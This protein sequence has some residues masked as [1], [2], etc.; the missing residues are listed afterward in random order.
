M[1]RTEDEETV[2]MMHPMMMLMLANQREH[3]VV[4]DAEKR[5]LLA[6]A[7]EARRA[8]KAQGVRGRP[9]GTLAS[10]EPSAAVPA[11]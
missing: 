10:C 3:D 8:R 1:Y 11:R 2:M 4:V 9:A 7:R 5:Q 6:S